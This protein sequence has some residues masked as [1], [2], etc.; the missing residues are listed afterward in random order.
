M[1]RELA[2][3]NQLIAHDLAFC[4]KQFQ[5][6]AVLYECSNTVHSTQLV[7]RFFCLIYR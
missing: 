5:E 6:A 1:E 2:P 4:Y 3:S 7:R